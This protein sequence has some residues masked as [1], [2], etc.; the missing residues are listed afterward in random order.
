MSIFVVLVIWGLISVPIG[1]I[2]GR[3]IESPDDG[4]ECER[5]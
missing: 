4:E 3:I 2:I 5:W 1:I